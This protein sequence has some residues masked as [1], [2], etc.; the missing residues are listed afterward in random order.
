MTELNEDIERVEIAPAGGDNIEA[1]EEEEG[2]EDQIPEKEGVA[3]KEQLVTHKLPE[4]LEDEKEEDGESGDNKEPKPVDG[5]TPRERALRLELERTRGLLRKE[6][7][8]DLGLGS[9][10]QP[11]AKKELSPEKAEI[12]KK[13]KPEEITALREVIPA[14]AEEM[15]FVK[16]QDLDTAQYS[17]KSEE[18]LQEFLTKHPEYMPEN[19]KGGLLWNS[20]KD[21]FQIYKQPKNPKDYTKIFN[22]IHQDVFGIKPIGDKGAIIAAQEKIKVASHSGASAPGRTISSR[23]KPSTTG[24]RLDMLRGFSEEDLKELEGG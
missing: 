15:G 21:Q 1:P 9:D 3:P 4:E 19:D 20:F 16:A 10:H 5:E 17:E 24:L 18:I 23:S 7:A 6:K 2:A 11:A 13:Y 22:R 14:L 12:L 8:D